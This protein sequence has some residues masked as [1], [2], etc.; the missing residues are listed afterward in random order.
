MFT[1][2]TKRILNMSMLSRP[3]STML[4]NSPDFFEWWFGKSSDVPAVFAES[5]AEAI[6]KLY[7]LS[8]EIGM[9]PG[10]PDIRTVVWEHALRG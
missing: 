9:I 7:E 1:A 3:D 10:F 4:R 2:L 8:K 5:H 6:M